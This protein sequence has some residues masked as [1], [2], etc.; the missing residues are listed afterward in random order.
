MS[1][2]DM[3]A[4]THWFETKLPGAGALRLER[5]TGGQSNPT[6]FADW[7]AHRFVLRKKPDGDIL[8]G[9][10]AIEREFRVMRALAETDVPVPGAL[11]LE[12]DT[13]ILGTPFYVME[14]VEGRVFED[15]T[16]PGLTAHERREIYLDMARTLARLHA[17]RPEA[18]GLG[19]FGRPGNYFERQIA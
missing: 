19:D 18:I 9:A 12:E 10:H 5:I 4:L 15:C 8:P 2:P 6:W 13:T 7:G 3:R 14:R 1:E 17:V 11:W 16:L